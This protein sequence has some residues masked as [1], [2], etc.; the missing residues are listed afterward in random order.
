MITPKIVSIGDNVL[1][2]IN[3]IKDIKSAKPRNRANIFVFWSKMPSKIKYAENKIMKM[4]ENDTGSLKT[5]LGAAK[6][7]MMTPAVNDNLFLIF[8]KLV[9]SIIII[10]HIWY[11]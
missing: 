10:L 2:A 11:K 3:H 8:I 4:L 9:T 7:N 1:W 5:P 6:S